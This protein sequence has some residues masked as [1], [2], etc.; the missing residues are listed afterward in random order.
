MTLIKLSTFL[1]QVHFF[2][3]V[4]FV[5]IHSSR[6]GFTIIRTYMRSHVNKFFKI[7]PDHFFQ[8]SV[9]GK[10]PPSSLCAVN[11]P[12]IRIPFIATFSLS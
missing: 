10:K 1:L 11:T 9:I 2:F 6:I 7:L 3:I 8:M 5:P 12:L 4:N